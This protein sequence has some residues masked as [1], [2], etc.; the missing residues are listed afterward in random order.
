MPF[1]TSFMKPQKKKFYCITKMLKTGNIA[2]T[3]IILFLILRSIY[4]DW[5]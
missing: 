5:R 1:M 2:A 4:G 3:D